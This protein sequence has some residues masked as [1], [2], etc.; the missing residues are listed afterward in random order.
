MK[1]IFGLLLA[2]AIVTPMFMACGG[3]TAKIKTQNDSLNYAFGAANADGIRQ[4][5]IMADTTD[6]AKVKQFCNGLSDAFKEQTTKE[7]LSMEG[8]RLGIS[9]KQEEGK[10]AL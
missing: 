2:V 6:A 8:F 9:M 3:N 5:V 7:R 1:K 4:Y 10:I